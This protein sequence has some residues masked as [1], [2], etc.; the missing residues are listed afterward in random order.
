MVRTLPN[1]LLHGYTGLSGQ[2]F[3]AIDLYSLHPKIQIM[4]MEEMQ[5]NDSEFD[6]ISMANV[7][8]YSYDPLPAF[9]K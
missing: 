6:C 9:W 3:F 4:S 2:I 1:Y 7:Y 8:G 5:Y